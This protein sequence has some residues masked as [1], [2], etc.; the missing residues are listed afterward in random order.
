MAPG[1]LQRSVRKS[2][3]FDVQRRHS[4]VF[5]TRFAKTHTRTDL[6]ASSGK[7]LHQPSPQE[8]ARAHDEH[9]H[10]VGLCQKKKNE[11]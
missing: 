2:L 8:P 10:H 1:T 9:T 3:I 7:G 5:G 4:N 11:I 6:M